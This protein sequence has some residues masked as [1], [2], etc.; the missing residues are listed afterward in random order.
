[1]D[2]LLSEFLTETSESLDALD[3]QLITLEQDPNDAEDYL[4]DH[5]SVTYLMGP[6][7][8]FETFVGNGAESGE[9][10]QKI[11]KS[12]RRNQKIKFAFKTSGQPR[13]LLA[14]KSDSARA[15]G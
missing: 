1:M 6:D 3:T 8:K 13:Y 2:D 10:V 4:M 14:R 9:I 12:M 15:R 5:S 7:G 11:L